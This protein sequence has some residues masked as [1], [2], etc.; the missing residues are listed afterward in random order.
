MKFFS[1]IDQNQE[2]HLA[3]G[4][5]CLPQKQIQK[6][7]EAQELI[8]LAKK[9]AKERQIEVEKQ[10]ELL[11]EEAQKEGFAK[12]LEMFNEAIAKVE[13]DLQQ[14]RQETEN[15]VV[16]LALKAA[17]KIV[18]REV[19]ENQEIVVDVVCNALKA[20][21]HHKRVIIYVNKADLDVLEKNRPRLK[22]V[23]EDLEM[24]SIQEREDVEPLGCIIETEQGII[25][26][27]IENQWQ[28]LEKAFESLIKQ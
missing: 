16:S 24:L 10:A 9:Q 2:I 27:Q 15:V 20:V 25:N 19:K 17:R 8:D 22:Q 21:C 14:I 26:A 6:L 3:A 5:K 1:L 4:V 7:L 28:S 11:K 12:G 13:S 23:L 18:A